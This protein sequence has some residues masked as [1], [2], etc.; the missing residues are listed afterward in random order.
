MRIRRLRISR[1]ADRT[2]ERLAD[3]IISQ[4]SYGHALK[5]TS[6]LLNEIRELSFLADAIKKSDL[7]EAKMCHADAKVLVTRNRKWSVIF[8]TDDYFVYVDKILPS[9]M[10]KG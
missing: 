8:H 4:S 10:I 1:S 7:N 3:F 5:Y 6:D 9:S 2:I